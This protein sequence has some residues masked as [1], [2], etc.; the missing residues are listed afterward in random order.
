MK[1][2]SNLIKTNEFVLLL[3][4]FAIVIYFGSI[5]NRFLRPANIIQYLNSNVVL[6]LLTFGLSATIITGNLDFSIGSMV[7]FGTVAIAQLITWGLPIAIAFLITLILLIGFG[8]LNGYIV[9]YLKIPGMLATLGTS[10][11]IYG[12][13]LVF[14]GGQTISVINTTSADAYRFFGKSDIG[15]IPFAMVLLAVVFIISYILMHH[16]R[17]GRKLFLIG[18]N[19]EAARFSGINQKKM[20]F[21]AHIYSAVMCFLG[22]VILGS[23]MASGRADVGSPFVLEAVSAAVFGGISIKGGKG[24]LTGALLGV[25]IFALLT[26]GFTMIDLSQYYRQVTTGI[27]LIIVLLTRNVKEIFVKP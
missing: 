18:E 8:A 20:V 10:S 23:R 16:T 13:A 4:L 25:L 24:S 17:F 7:G 19:P 15:K 22:A 1:K 27:L 3:L 12:I 5:N 21:L 2:I 26:S 14:T 6:G 11:L 9:G